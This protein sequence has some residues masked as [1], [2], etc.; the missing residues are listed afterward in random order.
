MRPVSGWCGSLGSLRMRQS[1]RGSGVS[2]LATTTGSRPADPT[3]LT[4]RETSG[5]SAKFGKGLRRAHAATEPSSKN[6]A[7]SHWAFHIPSLPLD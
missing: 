5:R 7:D 4:T 1:R 6:S 2:G 3:V